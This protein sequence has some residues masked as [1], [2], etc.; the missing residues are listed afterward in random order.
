MV[1]H[2][3]GPFDEWTGH[4]PANL[5]GSSTPRQR[6]D[7]TTK[8]GHLCLRAQLACLVHTHTHNPGWIHS[9]LFATQ[10]MN[11]KEDEEEEEYSKSPVPSLETAINSDRVPFLLFEHPNGHSLTQSGIVVLLGDSDNGE[12]SCILIQSYN[13]D[14]RIQ[15]NTLP[16][17]L[18]K[19]YSLSSL[20]VSVWIGWLLMRESP[21]V[22]LSFQIEPFNYNFVC[23]QLCLS[24]FHT[25]QDVSDWSIWV[26]PRWMDAL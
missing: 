4:Q 15:E 9:N 6:R 25:G 13:Q 21:F 12:Y 2:W 14:L 17:N 19:L 3:V 10:T 5:P 20:P 1:E 26:N 24:S 18:F 8:N 11:D 23:R 16:Q 7:Q 22:N